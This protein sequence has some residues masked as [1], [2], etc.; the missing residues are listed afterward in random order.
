MATP[1]G[2][3][4]GFVG[5][6]WALDPVHSEVTFT[7]RHL[8]VTKLKG[9]FN[10]FEGTVV[11]N[12]DLQ[13]AS[14]IASIDTASVHTPFASNQVRGPHFLDVERYPKIT[15]ASTAVRGH[16]GAYFIDG[17]LSIRDITRQVTLDLSVREFSTAAA[18]AV[19]VSFS[20]TSKINRS[21]FGVGWFSAPIPKL[22]NPAFLADTIAVSID[23]V[24]VRVD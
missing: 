24:L 7:V 23:A 2:N 14:V 3:I 13:R 6:R 10:T 12:K 20:A 21:D 15:F 18:S 16:D 11:T 8:L 5:G 17:D 1:L 22:D 19:R 4:P 9:R